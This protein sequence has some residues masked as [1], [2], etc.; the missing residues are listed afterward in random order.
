MKQ[1]RIAHTTSTV[2]TVFLGVTLTVA[3]ANNEEFIKKFKQLAESKKVDYQLGTMSDD[4]AI[5]L[6][7]ECMAGTVLVGWSNLKQDGKDVEFTDENAASLLYYD[8]EARKH[9]ESVAG[10]LSEFLVKGEN[11]I[12]EKS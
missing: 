12:A 7:C 4:D 8:A 1:I 2:D 5:K 10:N 6:M 3:R 11:A 9:V